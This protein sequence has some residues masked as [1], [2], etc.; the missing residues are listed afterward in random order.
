M[1]VRR[2]PVRTPREAGR[3][4][5]CP[6]PRS[7]AAAGLADGADDAVPAGMAQPLPHPVGLLVA[8]TG[9]HDPFDVTG[10][11]DA[12]GLVPDEHDATVLTRLIHGAHPPR[13]DSGK[14]GQ[15]FPA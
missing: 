13:R 14:G 3:G 12:L 15:A 11:A 10:P 7:V 6:P 9:R 4:G 5:G 1:A 8:G 2:R